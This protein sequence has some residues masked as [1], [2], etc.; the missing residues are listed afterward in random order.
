MYK[1]VWL[2]KQPN[3]LGISFRGV[4]QGSDKTRKMQVINLRKE[5]EV[6]KMEENETVRQ[7][8]DRLMKVV[9]RIRLLGEELIDK[10]IVE[11]VL[12]SLPK[13][14]ESNISSLE[15]SRYLSNMS[16]LELVNAL[17]ALK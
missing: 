1:K 13:K 9:N 2:V 10:K 14:F 4:F 3:K 7:Y 15:D 12:V 5:F 11:K 16:L 17:Q 6:L 8:T